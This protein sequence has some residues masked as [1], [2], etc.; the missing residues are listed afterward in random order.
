MDLI[1][2]N[3]LRG[4]R[5]YSYYRCSTVLEICR[6][7]HS[8]TGLHAAFMLSYCAAKLDST[9]LYTHLSVILTS[10]RAT[11]NACWREG[12]G[13]VGRAGAGWRVVSDSKRVLLGSNFDCSLYLYSSSISFFLRPVLSVNCRQVRF[14][15]KLP[16]MLSTPLLSFSPPICCT[17]PSEG[18]TT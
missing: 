5:R 8:V 3:V 1:Q 17:N 4:L 15:L 16:I 7:G 9:S 14:L 12:R 2:S 13:G 6:V 10:D 11:F 18:L